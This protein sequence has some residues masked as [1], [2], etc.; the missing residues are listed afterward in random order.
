MAD[1][2][3]SELQA[4]A[5]VDLAAGDE[6][7]IADISASETKKVTV[8]NLIGFGSALLADATIPSAKINFAAGAIVAAS[9]ASDAVT[10]AKINADAVTGPKLADQSTCVVAASKAALDAVT[11]DFV[12]Q[13]GLT[14]DTL[15]LYVWQNS[16]WQSAKAAGSINTVIGDTAGIVNVEATASND[17]I[18]LTAT[19]DNT[20]GAGQ[21]LAGP[22]GGAGAASYR[23]IAGTDLPTA[24]T[25][26]KGGVIVNGGGLTVSGSTIAIDNTVTPVSDQLRKVSYNAQGLVTASSSVAGGDL[27]V[28][29]SVV[30]GA[31][32][33]GTGLAVDNSGVLNHSNSVTGTTQNGITYDNQG[34]I[35][36]VVAL[37]AS[38]IPDLAATKITSGT[39]DVARIGTNTVTGNKLA[40]YAIT[41]IGDTQ[42]TADQIG[43]FFF[44][45]L[46]RD[47]FLWDGNVFQPIGISVGEIIFAGTFD[48]SAGGGTGLVATV[49]PEG[50][51][52]GLTVGSAL[53]AA[54]TANSRYYLVVNEAGTITSGNAPNVALAPPDIILSTGAEWTEVDVSQTITS[55]TANQVS[56]TPGGTVS[57]TN[58]QSAI[59]ELDS[60]K[61]PKAGGTVTGELLIGNTGSFAFEGS[62]D[63]AYET[64]LTAADPT[65]DRTITF[66]DQ[67]GNV[68]VSGNASIVNADIA[69]NAAIAF[70]KLASLTSAN[71]LV[72][73]SSNVATAVAVTGDVT[74]SNTGVTSIAAGAIVNADISASAAIDYSKL[75]TLTSGNIILG[76]ASNVATSTAVTGD[77]TISNTGVTSIAAGAIVNADIS[78]SAAIAFSK[79][80]SLTSANILVGN[81][82][83]VP[84]AVAVTGD[85]TLS[86]A[87]V[88]A[89]AAGVIVD[90]DI[91][92]SAA[93]ADTKL[94]TISTANK[95]SLA[96]L[97][98]DGASDIGAAIVDADLFIVDDGGAG[99]NRKAAASRISDYAFGKVT[100]DITIASN[101][102]A[103]IGSAVIV[104]ADISASAEIA[105]SKLANGTARQLLQT[106]SNGT[107]VEWTSNVDV[108]GTLDVTGIGTFDAAT[109]GAITALTSAS[110]VTPNFATTNHFSLTLAHSLTIANPTNLTAGQSGAIV[111]TQGASTAYTVSYGSNWKFSGG[112]PT[113]STGL[114]SVSTLVYYVESASRI[115]A[116]LITNVA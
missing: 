43:Q 59:D 29:T 49:T 107:D 70:S 65:L 76:N 115:T 37:T 75:A 5:G 31:V 23:T 95:V 108:P 19:L 11:G 12:G 109:R 52:I 92:A 34:H 58:V 16:A 2:K 100:G 96:A 67:S 110:T 114:S 90:A 46:T 64:Y 113:M 51:A 24:T 104:N 50:T 62:T 86:N 28:A 56:Y 7:A 55:V 101:G 42:P 63:N 111:I 10:T 89:I 102:T 73:N 26:A 17:T 93:I 106:A 54:A 97:D 77:V 81:G 79:L 15:K 83:N 60:E 71:I 18:T 45:P 4:L 30:V 44:N 39:L 91:N 21:F 22:T 94:A 69:T 98:I 32:R 88:T 80:A 87:G 6:L 35:T 116:Q 112:T 27:P 25:S 8:T 68:L 33:P 72:G 105:V 74:I 82:S 85:I 41:K 9:L 99:T 1:L 38:D 57:S 36:N 103:A 20:S 66:P 47:L 48:A 84:T 14:T 3:I 78:A 13:L 40:N 61:L 53:P